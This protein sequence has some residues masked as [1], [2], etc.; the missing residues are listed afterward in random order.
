MLVKC[1]NILDLLSD[2]IEQD[3]EQEIFIDMMEHI[4]HCENCL[5]L[6]HTFNKTLDL[7]HSM[8]PIKIPPKKKKVFHKWLHI[9]VRRIVVKRDKL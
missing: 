8:K 6:F 1:K 3:L 4:N 7:Y 2:L 5:A 9:E